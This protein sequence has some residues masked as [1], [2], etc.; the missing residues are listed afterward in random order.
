MCFMVIY[1]VAGPISTWCLDTRGLRFTLVCAAWINMVGAWV[2]FVGEFTDPTINLPLQF[3]GTVLA[4]LAQPPILVSS[5]GSPAH[6]H[7]DQSTL[8]VHL[9]SGRSL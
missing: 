2:R 7:T 6:T 4:A 5:E 9:I 3:V 1:L 8:L